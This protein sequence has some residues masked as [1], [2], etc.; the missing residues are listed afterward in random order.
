MTRTE[1]REEVL[2]LVYAADQR[3]DDEIDLTGLS[4]RVQ[5]LA[6]GVWDHRAELDEALE[7]VSDRWRVERMPAVDRNVLRLG[8]YELRYESD[9]PVGVIISQAVEL[10]KAYS[11]EQSGRFVN[12][13]LSRLARE[14]RRNG[15]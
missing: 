2:G 9:V 1:A 7:R 3:G 6:G 12:G 5:R 14:E 10:A 11:T 8:L 15:K 13:V 4:S